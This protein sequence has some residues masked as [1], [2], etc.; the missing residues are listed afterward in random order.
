MD[1]NYPACTPRCGYPIDIQAL[2]IAAL[3][4]VG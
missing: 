3:R 1:T 4:F 2:W